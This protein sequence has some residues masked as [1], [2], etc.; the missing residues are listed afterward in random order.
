[1]NNGSTYIITEGVVPTPAENKSYISTAVE[2]AGVTFSIL[3][4]TCYNEQL[5]TWLGKN[6]VIYEGLSGRGPNQHTGSRG[7]AKNAANNYKWA[8]RVVFVISAAISVTEIVDGVQNNDSEK[9]ADASSKLFLGAAMTF[10]GPI[11]FVVGGVCLFFY[12]DLKAAAKENP[13]GTKA[14]WNYTCFVAGTTVQMFD[15]SLKE[16]QDIKEG[17]LILS[18]NMHTMNVEVDTVLKLPSHVRRYKII[19]IVLD[20]GNIIEF[21]PCHPFWIVGKG[22][23]VFDVHEAQNELS[24]NV[25]KIEE[26]DFVLC[27]VNGKLEKRRIMSLV[28]T[29]DYTEMYNVEHVKNH[30]NFFANG[31]LVHN[32]FIY[33]KHNNKIPMQTIDLFH[34]LERFEILRQK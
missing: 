21:S 34:L 6:G 23:S 28:D 7:G 19:R 31:I 5:G 8:G 20:D 22:W 32:K 14:N 1:M 25:N 24:F 16:I 12:D 26:G 30:N 10:G 29:G 17:D 3:E 4:F 9:V 11:G 27:Y 18:L 13:A 33:P 15:G 2:I